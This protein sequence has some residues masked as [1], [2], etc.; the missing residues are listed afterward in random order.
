MAQNSITRFLNSPLFQKFCELEKI[1]KLK[2]KA[3]LSNFLNKPDIT[4]CQSFHH[5][6][7]KGADMLYLDSP[8]SLSTWSEIF[9]QIYCEKQFQLPLTGPSGRQLEYQVQKL[10]NKDLCLAL[11]ESARMKNLRQTICFTFSATC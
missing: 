5:S 7:C 8:N 3:L 1:C 9:C 11:M 6:E 2:L 4:K 10:V